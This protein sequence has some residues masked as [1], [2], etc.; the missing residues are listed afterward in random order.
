MNKYIRREL[1]KTIQDAEDFVEKITEGMKNG[2][3]INWGITLKGNAKIIGSICLWN[4]SS[5]KK[6]AE[7]GYDLHPNFQKR[8]IMDEAVKW[9]VAFGF[10]TLDLYHIEAFTHRRNEASKKLLVKN[11]FLYIENRKDKDDPNNII[12]ELKNTKKAI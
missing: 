6:I 12:F 5:D 8:G 11:N 4:F 2:K 9:V 7:I 3:N 10:E 1:A